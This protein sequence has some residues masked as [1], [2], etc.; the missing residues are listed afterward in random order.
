MITLGICIPTYKRPD[1]L[2][3]CVESAVHSAQGRPIA[4]YIAD[5]SVS[6]VNAAVLA[7]LQN[8]YPFVHVH[9]NEVNLGIDDN[10]QQAVGMCKCDFAWLIGED[11]TFLPGAVARVHD[12]VQTCDHAFIFANYHFVGND[13]ETV[14]SNTQLNLSEGPLSADAFL[15]E[16]LW[17]IGFIGACVVRCKEWQQT[18]PQPYQGTYYTHVGRIA[19]MICNAGSVYISSSCSVANRV[20]GG[21]S[22]TFTWWN[23]SYGVL[24]GFVKMCNAAKLRQPRH[25][26]ALQAAGD[27]FKANFLTLRL[28]LRLRAESSFNSAQ[29]TKYIESNDD[30]GKSKKTA[31]KIIS[32]TPPVLL[33]PIVKIYRWYRNNK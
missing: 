23:D 7:D 11:D 33:L 15:R 6:E 22:E 30:I 14:L 19:E 31:L 16:H 27:S 28:A 3:R 12:L 1:F 17:A 2:K 9:Q 18:D 20:E 24:F 26:D 8:R 25:A 21:G 32:L 4:V 5:D 29:Y 13:P 10:I